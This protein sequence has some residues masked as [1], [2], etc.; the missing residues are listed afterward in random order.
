MDESGTGIFKILE[1][2]GRVFAGLHFIKKYV[3]IKE[4]G[5]SGRPKEGYNADNPLCTPIPS[6]PQ[7]I[8]SFYSWPYRN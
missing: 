4:S 5:Y 8:C 2:R 6:L 1:A 3:I 7:V